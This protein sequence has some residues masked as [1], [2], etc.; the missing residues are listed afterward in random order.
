[1][2]GKVN[3]LAGEILMSEEEFHVTQNSG[4]LDVKGRAYMRIDAIAG[5]ARPATKIGGNKRVVGTEYILDD[6]AT[7]ITCGGRRW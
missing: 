5:R 3:V 7:P 2:A 1:M 4:Q 6:S